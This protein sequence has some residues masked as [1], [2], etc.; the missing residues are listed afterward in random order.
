MYVFYVAATGQLVARF[1]GSRRNVLYL[2]YCVVHF[3]V[4]ENKVKSAQQNHT[5]L[6]LYQFPQHFRHRLTVHIYRKL[7]T[8]WKKADL[9]QC[10]YCE[11]RGKQIFTL[12]C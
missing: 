4:P 7:F 3:V 11:L 12:E 8:G 1:Y 5:T 2:S 10:L 6:L 9:L